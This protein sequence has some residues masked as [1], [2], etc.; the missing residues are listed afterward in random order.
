MSI[1]IDQMTVHK[2]KLSCVHFT[3]IDHLRQI[4]NMLSLNLTI[5]GLF[6]S[7]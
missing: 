7:L 4:N 5:L 1:L 2:P 6:K 3:S